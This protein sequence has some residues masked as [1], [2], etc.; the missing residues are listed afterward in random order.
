MPNR[1]CPLCGNGIVRTDRQKGCRDCYN[2]RRANTLLSRF[3]KYVDKTDS[4][5]NWI[6]TLNDSGY[7]VIHEGK[8]GPQQRAHRVAWTIY[9]KDIPE[10]LLLLHRCDNRRCVREEHLFLGTHQDNTDDM[11]SKGRAGWQNGN[12]YFQ[13]YS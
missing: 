12:P 9:G 4:C 5:W 1:P 11:I 7:G 8:N 10:G 13:R 2:K 3:W 6:G